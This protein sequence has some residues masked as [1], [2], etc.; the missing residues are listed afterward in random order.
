MGIGDSIE[1][2]AVNAVEDLAGRPTG[3]TT[4]CAEPRRSE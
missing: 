2:A 4:A 3:L 1:E